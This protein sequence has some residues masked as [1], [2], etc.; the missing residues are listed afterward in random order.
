MRRLF[1][2]LLFVIAA[3]GLSTRAQTINSVAG[4]GVF[5]MGANGTLAV[6]C[7][8]EN[9]GGVACG[10][11]SV[12]Y[13]AS[14]S[15]VRRVDSSGI[16]TTV[17][18]GGT[19]TTDGIAATAA[20]IGYAQNIFV[21]GTGILYIADR[22]AR[23]VKRV[24]T[25][26]LIYNVAGGG[27]QNIEGIPADSFA[28][29]QVFGVVADATGNVYISDAGLHRVLRVD[30]AGIIHF[31]AGFGVAGWTA[32]GIATATALNAPQGLAIDAVGDVFIAD[33]YNQRIRKV[34]TS[35]MM[36]T[37]VG[38]GFT[39][40]SGDGGSA[41]A[42]AMD[43]PQCVAL[44]PDGSMFIGDSKGDRIRIVN[45]ATGVISTLTGD[46][47]PGYG[48][49][50]GPAGAALTHGVT[51]LAVTNEGSLLLSD[52][53]NFRIREITQPLSVTTFQQG[54]LQVTCTPNPATDQVT[55]RVTGQQIEP[56][57]VRVFS[58]LGR[59]V[60][61]IRMSSDRDQTLNLTEWPTGMYWVALSGY[62]LPVTTRKLIKR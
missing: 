13:F 40:Y 3:P 12:W 23:K 58:A 29:N 41:L 46:G 17:A 25:S 15:V 24:D 50:G 59:E 45:G 19:G 26:G 43:T 32:D 55:L 1:F 62:G 51:E 27:T 48:G 53:F 9:P 61:A 33:S 49:D 2:Y 38:S 5:G 52:Y 7:A 8:I 36:N 60:A 42:A 11:G 28:L 21:D 34:S 31:F 54:Q 44:L 4:T 14:R 57:V 37:V 30:T 22:T 56:C 6:D 10:H 35:G 20:A 18:G 16:V 39:G 47:I